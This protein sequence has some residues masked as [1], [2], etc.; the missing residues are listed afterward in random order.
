MIQAKAPDIAG[1]RKPSWAPP[2]GM[3]DSHFHIFGPEY[4]YPYLADRTFTPADASSDDYM[5]VC[6]TLGI[7]RAVL[8]QPSVYGTDNRRLID[9]VNELAMPTR[10]VVVASPDV[11]DSELDALHVAGARGLRIIQYNKAELIG[12]DL[13]Y[14]AGRLVERG[15]HLQM[16]I[17]A[18]QLIYLGPR[19]EKLRCPVVIDHFA[20]ISAAK[21][22][23]DLGFNS[24]KSLVD[25]GNCWL[26]LTGGYRI[27][28]TP[29]PHAD[30]IPLVRELVSR[31]PDRFVWGTDWPHVVLD[32]D[33][34]DT[35]DIVDLLVDWVPDEEQRR[36]ILV[37]NPEILYGF[38]PVGKLSSG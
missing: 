37:R 23:D 29:A 2:A 6:N 38:D 17:N 32:G 7:D 27:S 3:V 4:R 8:V 22:M 19:L 18:E 16:L 24:L 26:K 20:H 25:S 9:A 1:L 15:W 11:S 21:G 36:Q 34:P 13:E 33:A 10:A 35:T 5:R 14:L 28:T 30:A 31:R 12:V